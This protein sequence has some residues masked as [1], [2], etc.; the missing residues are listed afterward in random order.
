MMD[1]LRRGLLIG[2][3]AVSLSQKEA[4]RALKQLSKHTSMSQKEAEAFLKKLMQQAQQE[5]A[6]LEKI[7]DQK[8]KDNMGQEL[9]RIK[10]HLERLEKQLTTEGRRALSRAL[11]STSARTRKRSTRARRK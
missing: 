6:R 4:E 1:I 2:V 10:Q 5:R 7:I 3:G 9:N 8:T 11:S